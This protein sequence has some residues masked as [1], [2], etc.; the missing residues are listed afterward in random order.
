MFWLKKWRRKRISHREFP[1]EWVDLLK[2]QVPHYRN[3]SIEDQKELQSHILIFLAEKNFEGCGGLKITEEIKLTIA[4]QACL[5]LLHRQTDYFPGL[6][7]ILVYPRSFVSQV[8]DHDEM[9][10]VTED[11]EDRLGEAWD[12][13]PILLS[14]ED[15]CRPETGG[16]VVI[17]EFAHHIDQT[18]GKGDH[19]PVLD[20]GAEFR[21]WARVL[22]KEYKRLKK[23]VGNNKETLLDDYGATDPSEFFAVAT[24][25]F[26]EQP[27]E[28]E[29]ES[30][31]L[32]RAL[33]QFY[34]QDPA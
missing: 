7:S 3:L 19:S 21:T 5:L 22:A 24:E 26:F 11:R 18:Q 2:R 6:H 4:A 32:Y 33:K 29:N 34:Q 17:H 13:G 1:A 31:E 28:L 16:N 10:V 9:G 23:E 27:R 20:G 15:I 8:E 14:W 25:C 30:P 12:R